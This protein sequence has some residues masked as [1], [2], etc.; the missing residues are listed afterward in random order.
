MKTDIILTDINYIDGMS[1]FSV[2]FGIVCGDVIL[3][4]LDTDI[5]GQADDEAFQVTLRNR[6]HEITELLDDWIRHD[7]PI[8]RA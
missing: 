4:R 6:I 2:C 1:S 5:P 7:R 8:R 3:A